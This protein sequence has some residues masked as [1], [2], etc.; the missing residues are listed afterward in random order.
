MYSSIFS[1]RNGEPVASYEY[2]P[3]FCP[4]EPNTKRSQQACALKFAKKDDAQGCV[5]SHL[6]DHFSKGAS[7]PNQSIVSMNEWTPAVCKGAPVILTG[8]LLRELQL[9]QPEE[10]QFF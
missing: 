7:A 9:C 2:V 5:G 6:K 4:T 8:G 1:R 10:L 3:P